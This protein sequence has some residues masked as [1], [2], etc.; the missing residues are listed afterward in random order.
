[1]FSPKHDYMERLASKTHL[2]THKQ[3]GWLLALVY[4]KAE[5]EQDGRSEDESAKA[6]PQLHGPKNN[7]RCIAVASQKKELVKEPT[8]MTLKS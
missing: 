8:E 4:C 2:I 3:H 1:M 7:S 5:L 6:A